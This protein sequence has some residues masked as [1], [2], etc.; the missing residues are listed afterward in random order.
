MEGSISQAAERVGGNMVALG[1]HIVPVHLHKSTT[2]APNQ[3]GDGSA[4]R[5][6]GDLERCFRW[7]LLI[8]S[9]ARGPACVAGT[10]VITERLAARR[11]G[12]GRPATG[13]G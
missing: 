9:R 4:E 8:R 6:P 7:D 2:R 3:D 11:R 13:L 10:E 12:F 1:N 5:P